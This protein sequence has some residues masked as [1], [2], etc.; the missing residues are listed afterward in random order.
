[1]TNEKSKKVKRLVKIPTGLMKKV[2]ADSRN[3]GLSLSA[4]VER[5]IQRDVEQ[6]AG[7]H[8]GQPDS[9]AAA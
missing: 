2:R 9:R 4:I 5:A 1:M 7:K 6:S 3:K 8:G